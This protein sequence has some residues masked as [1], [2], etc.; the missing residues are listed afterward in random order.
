MYGR[1]T[2]SMGGPGMEDAEIVGWI[3][4]MH[5]TDA[6][7]FFSS[8]ITSMLRSNPFEAPTLALLFHHALIF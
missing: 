5:F 2:V 3:S 6:T 7:T 4:E 1:I 8:V